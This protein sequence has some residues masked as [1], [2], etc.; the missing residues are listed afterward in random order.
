[1]ILGLLKGNNAS[2]SSLVN[3]NDL[4]HSRFKQRIDDGEVQLVVHPPASPPRLL[5]FE[6]KLDGQSSYILIRFDGSLSSSLL[7]LQGRG[8]SRGARGGPAKRGG[9]AGTAS[10]QE[11]PKREA[12]LDLSRYVGTKVR[13]TFTGGRQGK[14]HLDAT[15]PSV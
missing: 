6:T 11:K 3:R 12:I 13:V 9:G 15:R 7:R 5:F 14:L 8:A 2:L 10:T 4:G 1:M